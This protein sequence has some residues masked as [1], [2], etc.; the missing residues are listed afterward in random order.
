M[1]SV[2]LLL[3]RFCAEKRNLA[4]IAFRDIS[5]TIKDENHEEMQLE[6]QD[7][8]EYVQEVR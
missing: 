1:R 8:L 4:G 6:F 7:M 5:W 2:W 3:V